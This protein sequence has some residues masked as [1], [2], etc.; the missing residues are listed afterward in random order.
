M[1]MQLGKLFGYIRENPALNENTLILFCSDNG[2]EPG[3][4][5]ANPFKGYKT[6]LYEGGIRSPLIA[7]GPGLLEGATPGIRNQDSVFAAIDLVPSLLHLGG[8]HPPEGVEFDGEDMLNTLLG[9][10][11]TSREKPLFF[12]RPPDRKNFYGIKN[13]PDLA[14]RHGKWKLLCDYDGGRPELYDMIDDPGETRNLKDAHPDIVQFLV[15]QVMDWYRLV[16]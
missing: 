12:S 5:Q 15:E 1:D 10:N 11:K 3:A 14:V 16:S 7:W 13:L 4:G 2:P 9:K 8:A 6:H